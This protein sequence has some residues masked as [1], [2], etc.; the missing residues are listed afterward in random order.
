MPRKFDV[1]VSPVREVTLVGRADLGHWQR[2]LAVHGLHP[3]DANGSAEMLLSSCE[4]R[5]K[6]IRFRELSV[7]VFVTQFAGGRTR[8]GA[9]L[10][11]A[12]NSIRFFAFVERTMFRTPY[13]PQQVA[14]DPQV[15]A[16][17]RLGD[18]AQPV[19]HAAMN[20]NPAT[21]GRAAASRDARRLARPDLPARSSQS[22]S[23]FAAAVLRQ[24]NR[25]QADDRLRC[26][27]GHV[28]TWFA[29]ARSHR[30]DSHRVAVCS[31]RMD[32]ADCRHAW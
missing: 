14:L 11:R 16:F 5:F 9:F 10:L 31:A 7:S 4:A 24:L 29:R 32:S 27:C 21:S 6:G 2:N 23:E 30:P 28:R 15:P 19:L 1:V 26:R 3:T 25:R 22:P 18:A 8:D 12:F 20:K 13:Y 17:M